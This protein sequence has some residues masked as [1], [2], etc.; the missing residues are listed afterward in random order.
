VSF[1]HAL[2][3]SHGARVNITSGRTEG[4][5]TVAFRIA[6]AMNVSLYDVL[7]G[8]APSGDTQDRPV[9]DT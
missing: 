7:N 5:A 1:L 2:P 8:T 9:V 3:I 4:S 6:R